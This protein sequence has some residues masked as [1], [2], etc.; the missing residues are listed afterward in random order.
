MIIPDIFKNTKVQA[1]F[2]D[3]S[4]GSDKKTVSTLAGIAPDRVLYV[5]QKHT[6]NVLIIESHKHTTETIADAILTDQQGILIGIKV[7]DCV[8]VLLYDNKKEAVGA[9]HAGWRGTAAGIIKNAINL[10][11]EHFESEP[12]DIVIAIGPSI[13]WCCYEV[14]EDVLNAVK[15]QTG[16]GEYFIERDGRLCLDLPSANIAQ[17][18]SLGVRVDNI[19]I[20]GDCTFCHPERFFSYR[21]NR[22]ERRQGGYIGLF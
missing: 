5:N 9:V 12:E 13:K 16:E 7:A 11:R 10:M 4:E 3:R 1:F 15:T 14:S 2:T 18:I 17:A 20:S 6:D 21:Y 8:P 22:T 19:W